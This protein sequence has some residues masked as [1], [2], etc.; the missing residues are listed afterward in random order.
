MVITCYVLIYH[1]HQEF[2]SFFFAKATIYG[3]IILKK[4]IVGSE[5]VEVRY[6]VYFI[7]PKVRF[8]DR[9]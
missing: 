2:F 6:T 1:F 5:V 9:P 8:N 4:E 3:K 7:P